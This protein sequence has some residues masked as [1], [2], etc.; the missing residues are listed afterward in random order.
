MKTIIHINFIIYNIEY[1]QGITMLEKHCSAY[2]YLGIDGIT[3]IQ[4]CILALLTA[5]K[6]LTNSSRVL[7]ELLENRNLDSLAVCTGNKKL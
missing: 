7:V 2:T 6:S 1:F 3:L 5:R 4:I